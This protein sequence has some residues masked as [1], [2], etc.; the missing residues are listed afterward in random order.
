MGSLR[1][2]TLTA[3]L[4]SAAMPAAA[5]GSLRHYEIPPQALEKALLQLAARNGRQITFAPGT[6]RGRVSRPLSGDF[7]LEEAL[8]RVL[9]GEDLRVDASDD[10]ILVLPAHYRPHVEAGRDLPPPRS[11]SPPAPVEEV[12]VTALKRESM[13]QQT[14]ISM[15]VLGRGVGERGDTSVND[16]Y[17]RAPGLHMVAN[18]A[19]LQRLAI[20][21][22]R[23]SG[24]ATTGVYYD[25]TPVTGPAGSAA[26]A[27]ATQPDLNLFDTQ[28]IEILR[29]PQGTLYG[30]GSMG[31]T[32]RV[33]FNKP[34]LRKA[35]GRV[36]V[37]GRLV[38]NGQPDGGVRLMVNQPLAEERLAL[39]LVI[40]GDRS[41]GYVDNIRLGRRDINGTRSTGMRAA[42]AY[43][44]TPQLSLLLS[45]ALQAD[46][47]EDPLSY[48]YPRL[49]RYTNDANI[50]GLYR[51]DIDLV[52]GVLKWELPAGTLT[53]TASRYGWKTIYG[54]DYT[55]TL[56]RA[57][58]DPAACTA[59]FAA[60]G[61]CNTLQAS[62]FAA[63]AQSR[64]PGVWYQPATLHADNQEVRFTSGNGGPLQWTVGA[65]FEDRRD[66]FDSV[67]AR[68]D[69]ATGALL[70]NDV[71]GYRFVETRVRQRALFGEGSW[72]LGEKLTLT[73]GARRY[74]YNKTVGG[75][76][77]IPNRITGS[78]LTPYGEVQAKA[79][80]WVT[81]VG[82]M[83]AFTSRAMV[84]AVRSEGF[85]PGGANNVPGAG[86]A[87][88]ETYD[89]D[90][91]VNYEL[92]A[93]TSWLDDRL[94]VNVTGFRIDWKDMQVSAASTSG[95]WR[96]NTNA[97]RARINGAEAEITARPLTGVY[98]SVTGAF[99]DAHLIEDQRN[100]Y[101]VATGAAG[102]RL[103]LT[104]RWTGGVF[105]LY[106]WEPWDEVHATARFDYSYVGASASEFRPNQITY[107]KQ[108]P[109]GLVD[110]Q[111]GAE[112]GA[113]EAYVRITNLFNVRA[114]GL[115]T[116]SL[117]GVT[118]QTYSVRP[119]A[120]TLTLK[121]AF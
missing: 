33:I 63:Y 100:P 90:R 77:V 22:V 109:H 38:T 17:R 72:R 46:R 75:E 40:Y 65:Y 95:A 34:D 76:V 64:T 44:P 39:R 117:S 78:E 108:P 102:D 13:P 88:P 116:T 106:R 20:R 82:L 68:A 120:V 94:I 43:A 119:R 107:Q 49:G 18:T 47:A 85:R 87:V 30:A 93:K 3:L 45:V 118:G 48:W 35:S 29:G 53:A 54:S 97:G 110:I 36:E 70:L 92:G 98:I 62:M 86:A 50:S 25:E 112:R 59:Y 67:V 42:L 31:G 6:V 101:G 56:Q 99:V 113:A 23:S 15:T 28:R 58:A 96:F 105:A 103:P 61:P 83:Y 8:A 9:P 104:P 37:R 71:T 84:Y 91:L 89:P 26:D 115:I 5:R 12:A 114:A 73:V 51:S 4:L 27:G 80:G 24:E 10:V 79:R 41:G 52:S 32:V 19:N 60:G 74:D 57:A 121:R 69:T 14:P 1:L 21:G 66:H 55:S 81:K 111:L 2:L 16:Y 11:E 7:T